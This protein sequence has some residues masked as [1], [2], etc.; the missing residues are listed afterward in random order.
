MLLRKKVLED[1]IKKYNLPNSVPGTVWNL[2]NEGIDVSTKTSDANMLIQVHCNENPFN[3]VGEIGIA[4]PAKLRQ[5]LSVM[6]ENVDVTLNG[7]YNL[8]ISNEKGDVT[9]FFVLS[10]PEAIGKVPSMKKEPPAPLFTLDMASE[11]MQ[12]V[13]KSIKSFDSETIT[14]MKDDKTGKDT[15]VLGYST[16]NTNR[17]VIELGELTTQSY[18]PVSFLSDKIINILS[19][20]TDSSISLLFNTNLLQLICDATDFKSTYRIQMYGK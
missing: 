8:T 19:A 9:G 6:G 4:E 13:I 14:F 12:N 3:T 15:I 2:S 7:K 18:N 1:F 16:N 10:T 17:L 11:Q 20:N 5:I